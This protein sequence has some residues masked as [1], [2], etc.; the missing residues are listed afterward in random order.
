MFIIRFIFQNVD[1][2]MK[3]RSKKGQLP[4]I[5][6]NG[7]EIADSAIIIRELSAKF[8]KDLNAGL[9]QEQ[10]N[11]AHATISMIE[12]HLVWIL[13]YWRTKNPD[14]L[15]KGYKVNLQH[16]LG[17]RLPNSILNFF[18][19]FTYGRKVNYVRYYLYIS[20]RFYFFSSMN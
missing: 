3:F 1:H 20:F 11:I 6:L 15:I 9:T 5:E 17:C 7:E 4:F 2:K 13:F 19:R 12:N 14:L 18:F 8:D 10:R 16:A